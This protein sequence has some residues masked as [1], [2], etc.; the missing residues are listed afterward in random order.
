MLA[1]L[2]SIAVFWVWNARIAM[3][4]SGGI[5]VYTAVILPVFG[6]C[7]SAALFLLSM[8]FIRDPRI[9][10]TTAI[11][12]AGAP[13]SL[14]SANSV[15]LGTFLLSIF[16]ILFSV[17]RIRN[18]YELSVGFSVSKIVKE[19]LPLY[20]TVVSLVIS[21]FYLH[22]VGQ[23]NAIDALIPRPALDYTFRWLT[24]NPAIFESFGV[25]V[26]NPDM[27]IDGV[28]RDFIG[29]ELAGQGERNKIPELE[30][31]RLIGE[32]RNVLAKQYGISLKGS[33]KVG[34]V[35]YQAAQE[36]TARLAGPYQKY[37]PFAAAAAFFF[38]FKT[39]TLP[40]YYVTLFLT[41]ILIKLLLYGNILKRESE[42]IE[43]E[44]IKLV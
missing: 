36:Y 14:L 44:R 43:V 19:G 8:L 22:T 12:A 15:V 37:L 31:S 4:L 29:Q 5:G 27:T 35:L 9:A 10:Y 40:L 11:I 2:S 16:L 39:L 21:V 6:L 3:I 1:V 17:R 25:P 18:E 23:R 7:V 34:D 24:K 41:Y 38:A 32:Q 28:L 13:Y 20:F 33:E 42:K 26:I 30:L